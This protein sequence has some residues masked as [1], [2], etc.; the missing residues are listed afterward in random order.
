M[1]R[2]EQ[3]RCESRKEAG[4]H[5]GDAQ[6]SDTSRP[7]STLCETIHIFF[8]LNAIYITM[9]NRD[10]GFAPL[11]VTQ[12]A[13]RPAPL[14]PLARRVSAPPSAIYGMARGRTKGTR[15]PKPAR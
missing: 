14:E 9:G 8:C 15:T 5:S 1:P 10:L 7:P 6:R 2:Y 4:E 3:R 11:F 12:N 13:G